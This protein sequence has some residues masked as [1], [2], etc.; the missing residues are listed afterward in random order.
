[1]KVGLWFYGLGT[2]LTG[3]MNIMWGEFDGSH[4]PI[5]AL[6]NNI[7]GEH[8]LAYLTGVW[9]AAA[10]LA[11]LW[12]RSARIGAV[13]SAVAYLMFAALWAVRYYAGIHALGWSMTVLL[14][15]SFG[16]AQQL[17]LAAGAGIIYASVPEGGSRFEGKTAV[18]ARW[19]L[20]VPPVIFGLTHLLGIHVFAGIV[21]KWIPF[22]SF[23][24]AVTGIAF[25]LG[26]AAICAGIMDVLAARLL[27]LMLLLFEPLVEIP[28]AV[29]K[30]HDQRAWSAAVYNVV[31]IGACWMFAEYIAS[32]ADRERVGPAGDVAVSRPDAVVA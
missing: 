25:L 3:I 24:A 16:L 22:A 8:F 2:A 15:V 1:M 28:P 31:A 9:L 13:G 23:W 18:I 20:G 32:R 19:M 6:G 11:V 29:A 27:A 7:P 14:G 5:K 30:L 10:G 12:R 26:G 21:P 17:M 4:E